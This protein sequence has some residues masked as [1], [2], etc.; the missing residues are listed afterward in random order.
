MCFWNERVG[1]EW[2]EEYESDRSTIHIYAIIDRVVAR[3]AVDGVGVPPCILAS[4]RSLV[5]SPLLHVATDKS[6]IVTGFMM[7][8]DLPDSN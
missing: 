1:R 6:T 7:A 5:P 2:K 4:A 8:L 3:N